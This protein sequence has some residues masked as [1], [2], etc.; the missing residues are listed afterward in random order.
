MV[1]LPRALPPT[2]RPGRYVRLEL[3]REPGPDFSERDRAALT[4]LGPHLDQAY[5]DVQRR[6][7]PVLPAD[8]PGR[9]ACC[10]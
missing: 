1:C 3:L 2:T 7:H 6:R 10:T 8:P 4:L 5:L 9:P